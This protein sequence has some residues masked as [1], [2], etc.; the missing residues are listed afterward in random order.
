M[1]VICS[2]K[3]KKLQGSTWISLRL[4]LAWIRFQSIGLRIIRKQGHHRVCMCECASKG[5]KSLLQ[6]ALG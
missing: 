4:S 5:I 3:Y 2:S 6:C 1:N